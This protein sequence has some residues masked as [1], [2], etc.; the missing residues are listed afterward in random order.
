MNYTEYYKT[1][2]LL[3]DG[4]SN[5]KMAKNELKTFGLSLI[6]HSLNTLGENICKF[7]TKECR[8]ACLNT[9]GHGRF[10]NVQEARLK[11]TDYFVNNK[12]AFIHQLYRE[13]YRINAKGKAAIRLN[14]VSDVD[15][16]AEFNKFDLSL[17]EFGNIIFYGYTKNPYMIE[18]NDNPNYHFT[19]S[20]SGWKLEMV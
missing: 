13:L 12:P 11:K 3:A 15:W 5:A 19:F 14:V 20:F 6:P 16:E 18:F 1:R 9:S 7:S 17:K 4:S 8:A 2:K 10:N